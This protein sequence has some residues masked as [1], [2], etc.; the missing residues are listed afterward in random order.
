LLVDSC[1]LRLAAEIEVGQH[2]PLL[3]RLNLLNNETRY[4]IGDPQKLLSPAGGIGENDHEKDGW[5]TTPVVSQGGYDVNNVRRESLCGPIYCSLEQRLLRECPW[6]VH[7]SIIARLDG[8]E[9]MI[10]SVLNFR[11]LPNDKIV[12]K[13]SSPSGF[14]LEG[15]SDHMNKT[16]KPRGPV[17]A[18]VIA[19]LADRGED[20]SPFFKGTGRMVQPIQRVNVDVTGSRAP[21]GF[22]KPR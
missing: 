6:E 1:L 2:T 17:S 8:D 3:Q 15:G 18:D 19:R 10:G 22:R 12:R 4:L 21:K 11:T 13:R 16:R 14:S 5:R 7:E 9:E 20:I